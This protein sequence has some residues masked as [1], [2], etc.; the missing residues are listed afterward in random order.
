MDVKL[1]VSVPS[2]PQSRTQKFC[3]FCFPRS[4]VQIPMSFRIHREGNRASF[5]LLIHHADLTH[6]CCFLFFW[7]GGAGLAQ[8]QAN[9]FQLSFPFTSLPNLMNFRVWVHETDEPLIACCCQ[10]SDLLLLCLLMASQSCSLCP[11]QVSWQRKVC[12]LCHVVSLLAQ[13]AEAV[14]CWWHKVW[15]QMVIPHCSASEGCHSAVDVVLDPCRNQAVVLGESLSNLPGRALLQFC[16]MNLGN[17]RLPL[18]P[19]IFRKKLLCCTF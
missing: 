4:K 9:T 10:N 13:F 3:C 6:A 2:R 17:A 14:L 7:G 15:Q 1:V 11:L 18:Q 19:I 16:L 12:F 8:M 5:K